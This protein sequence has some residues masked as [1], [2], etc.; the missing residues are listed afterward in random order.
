MK[1][2]TIFGTRPEII[3]LSLVMKV[4]DQHCE[5]VTVHTGQNYHESLSDIFI[6][7]LE[8]RTPD[9]HLGIRSA[10]FAG[11]IGQIVAKCDEAIVEHNPD[12]I[13]ILGDT[14]SALSAITAARR[15]I[16]VFHMEAGNRCFDDRV[17][18]EVNRRIID[19]SSAVLLPYTERS[20]ENLVRE[21]IERDRIFVTGNPIKEV[22]D[23]YSPK[24][25]ES[26]VLKRLN[27]RPFEYF[28]VTLHRAENV[29][30]HDRLVGIFKAFS[31]IS[32]KFGKEIL[33]SVHPRTAEKINQ[34]GIAPG[35]DKVRLLDAF[36]FFD[37][38]KLEK[39]SLAVMTDSGTV[40]EECAIFG[41][42]NVTIRDVT[43]RP[44]TI[45]CGSN[46]L[47]GADPETIVRAV[48][49][50]MAQPASWTA[51]KEYLAENVSQVVSKIVLGYLSRRQHH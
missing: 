4:L 16:P 28:L 6:R 18:E 38:V 17:P 10:S 21:G 7:D 8:V 34:F 1:V 46:I 39:N 47:S 44:E 24:I 26:D 50:A 22:L 48:E 25:E 32:E 36:G 5:H 23:F 12:R 15:Q 41:I 14:N 43:E 29:D 3:R 27:V 11:Q 19:H 13:L 2:M 49:L 31:Q 35:S 37:F 9:V 40:Q 45:E 33:I 30:I 51:P 20:K 42:P